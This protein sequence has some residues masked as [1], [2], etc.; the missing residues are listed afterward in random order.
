MA[1]LEDAP[2]IEAWVEIDEERA[3]EYWDPNDLDVTPRAVRRYIEGVPGKQF[4]IF[5]RITSEFR[6]IRYSRAIDFEI[7][8]H[9]RDRWIVTGP[10]L[11]AEG[12]ILFDY[13]G[14]YERLETGTLMF[15]PIQFGTL[16]IG[17]S[18]IVLN[19][20]PWPW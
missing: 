14:E 1:I 7:D 11:R 8:G 12:E 15:Q 20:R 4:K 3:Q 5:A 10:Q 6:P 18:L 13:G 9:H 19:W 16:N 2:D 17:M